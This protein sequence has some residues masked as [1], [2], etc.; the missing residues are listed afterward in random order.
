MDSLNMPQAHRAKRACLFISSGAL[1]AWLALMISVVAENGTTL[2]IVAI[3]ML[4]LAAH[5]V[6]VFLDAQGR[7]HNQGA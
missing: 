6:S 5:I 2:E 7:S 4:P 1:I 3:T